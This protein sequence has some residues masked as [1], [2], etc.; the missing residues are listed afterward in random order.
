MVERMNGHVKDEG[1][2][3]TVTSVSST[4][5]VNN[6]NVPEENICR[7]FLRNVCRR[8]KRCKFRHPDESEVGNLV[9]NQMKTVLTFC[10]DHQ[11][12]NCSRSLCKLVS[13]FFFHL[14]YFIF[15]NFI[16]I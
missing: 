9:N 8:G 10:H 4:Y 7:D 15:H 1:V 2:G 3:G 5:K 11:N 6:S 12:G 13:I 16:E 14:L